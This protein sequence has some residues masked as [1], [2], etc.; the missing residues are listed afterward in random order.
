MMSQDYFSGPAIFLIDTLIS[1]YVF[2]L[3]ARFLLQWTEADYYNPI[4]R[5]L[6]KIT[7]PILKYWKKSVRY[8]GR[9]DMAAL[10]VMLILQT[11][12]LYLIAFIQQ[13][14]LSPASLAV[15]ALVQLLELAYN[16]FFYSIL[17]SAVL[18]WVAPRG[19][20]PA[21]AVLFALAEPPLS[22]VRRVLPPIGGVDLSPILAL[23][24][25]Q[26]AKMVIFPPLQQLIAM[27]N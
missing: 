16:I 22:L 13:V 27:L 8:F 24:G 26:F 14:S 11:L 1:L 7:D 9:V 18:S 20:N 15:A 3:M 21:V 12:D 23:I 5:F 2:A 4:C 17:I 6:V 25:L 19:Y 10:T